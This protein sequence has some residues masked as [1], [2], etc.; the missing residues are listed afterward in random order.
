MRGG[1]V[2]KAREDLSD[3]KIAV[4]AAAKSKVYR[5]HSTYE[6]RNAVRELNGHLYRKGD[7]PEYHLVTDEDLVVVFVEEDDKIVVITQMHVHAD[8]RNEGTYTLV[9]GVGGPEI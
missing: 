3:R 5:L 6:L 7:S 4:T 2:R 8:Y 1:S 9:D